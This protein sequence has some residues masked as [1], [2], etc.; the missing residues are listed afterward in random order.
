MKFS[1]KNPRK[2]V[3][4]KT[5]VMSLL[6]LIVFGPIAFAEGMGTE[7]QAINAELEGQEIPSPLNKLFSDER[8]NIYFAMAGEE[9][10]VMGLTTSNGKFSRLSAGELE[11]PS[12]NLYI[13]EDVAS[14]IENS[15]N[16]GGTLQTALENGRIRYEAVGFFNRIKFTA[17]NLMIKVGS[18]FSS[19]EKPAVETSTE[20]S[21]EEEE[22]E[23]EKTD[24]ITEE[25]EIDEIETTTEESIGEDINA[26]EEAIVEEIKTNIVEMN[27]AGF[28]QIGTLRI[29]VGE[30][31]E[32]KNVRTGRLKEAMIIGTQGCSN[33][34]ST[35]FDPGES[36]SWTF[37][38]AQ[39]C[40]VVD[41][42]YTTQTMKLEVE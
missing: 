16:P 9:D 13:A 7:M 24:A 20:G 5:I 14:E 22:E 25:Q 37:D 12:L 11:N 26:E 31:V 29:K 40:T 17:I 27:N 15:E 42:V 30:T 34:K 36:F 2:N 28:D 21:E 19:E 18:W 3:F 35:F 32:W 8:I 1:N 23:E 41:G 38:K 6:F 10:V 33:V 4:Q 39:D